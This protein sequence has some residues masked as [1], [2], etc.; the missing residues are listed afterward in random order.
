MAQ[1]ATM[2]DGCKIHYSH[3]INLG[4]PTLVLSNSLGTTMQMWQPQ[5][6]EF[7]RHYSVV[8]YDIRGHGGSDVVTGAYSMDRL[9]C[10]IIGLLDHL[11]LDKV[12]FCGLSIGGMMGQWLAA[13]QPERIQALVLANTS[14]LITPVS[15]WQ[16]RIAHVKKEGLPS[17]WLAV[18]ARWVSDGFAA[19]SPKEVASMKAMFNS[20]D[21]D[22][23]LGCCAAI[24]DMDMRNL[25]QLNTVPTLLIA[26]TQD[27][28]T[29][30]SHSEY[31]LNKYSKASILKLSAG[32]LSNIEQAELFTRG[33]LD[34][35]TAQH[36]N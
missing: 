6:E 35:L 19:N 3:H 26:G 9:G 29:P 15:I 22:G 5:L 28:A 20:I 2:N 10:D 36:R 14:A 12:L 16:D 18:L 31:L 21:A 30:A 24:R 33:V 17:I 27:L 4:K 25:A 32:H 7:K 13:F 11:K 8:V 34:F 1:F 23:Y